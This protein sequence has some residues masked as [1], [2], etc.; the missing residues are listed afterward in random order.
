[1]KRFLSAE[2]RNL[3]MVNYEVNEQ[4]LLPYLPANTELDSFNNK[5]Y[6]SLVAFHFLNTK[7]KGIAF[8]FH[9]NFEEINLRFYVKYKENGS[10]KR[11]VVFISEIVPKRLIAFVARLLYGEK[12]EYAPIHSSLSET[13]IRNLSFKWG[14]KQEHSLNVE[15]EKNVLPL[16]M[17]S[18]AHFIYEH[19]WGYS[20]LK[21]GATL[22]YRVE[23]PSWNI[24][25]VK[26]YN[27]NVDFK[28]L[29]GE[30]FQFL[31]NTKPA[32]VFVAEGSPV[33]IYEGKR[34]N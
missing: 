34:I 16:Q 26:N 25:P 29:Y 19:Y 7:V 13:D 14:K 28:L 22:E 8:P 23:H 6:V 30:E 10:Y 11:G 27:L 20:R 31:N 1:M 15:C 33:V 18:K 32:S 3:V 17:S 21:N 5:F 2:W 9:Q 24:Y 4:V 12:Y